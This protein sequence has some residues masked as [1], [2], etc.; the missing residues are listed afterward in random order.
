MTCIYIHLYQLNVV[1]YKKW[2]HDAGSKNCR[3]L[4]DSGNEDIIDNLSKNYML[5]V[6]LYLGT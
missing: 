3:I 1:L 5:L 6:V 2:L 4:N